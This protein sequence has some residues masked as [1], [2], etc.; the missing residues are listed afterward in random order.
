MASPYGHLTGLHHCVAICMQTCHKMWPLLNNISRFLFVFSIMV[1]LIPLECD[2]GKIL[3]QDVQQKGWPNQQNVQDIFV[4]QVGR[5]NCGIVSCALLMSAAHLQQNHSDVAKSNV[6]FTEES[7]FTYPAT[8]SVAT[9]EYVQ[10]NGL[11]LDEV[12]DI[13]KNHGYKVDKYHA[14]DSSPEHFREMAKNVLLQKNS[15]QGIIVNYHMSVLGQVPFGGHHSPLAGYHEQE[16]RLLLM[17]VWPDTPI[18]WVRP[19]DLFK[20][21]NTTDSSSNKLRGFCVVHFD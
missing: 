20:A 2:E 8:L 6:P 9:A 21:M 12:I 11:T 17:D 1:D 19:A 14:S 10:G 16:D 4:K 7:M 15:K 18:S 5:S 13:L 3:L